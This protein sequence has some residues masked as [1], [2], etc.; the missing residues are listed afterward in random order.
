M[1]ARSYKVY[2]ESYPYF[3]TSGIRFGL[4]IFSDPGA[5]DIILENLV[6]L[7]QNKRIMI[8]AYVIMENHF[9]AIFRGENLTNDIGRFKSYSARRI[10]DLFR[11]KRRTRWLKRLKRVKLK[12]KKD[13]EYQLWEEGFHPKQIIS[14]KMMIQKIDYIH[15]NPVKRGFVDE[16]VHWRY[17]SAR[18]YAG[19]DGLI[20]VELFRGYGK[21]YRSKKL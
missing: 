1:C 18:N 14:D 12:F 8:I 11:E 7:Q 20:S 17:S 21:M 16:A 15:Q 10:I 4:P 19:L 9:H 2:D 5:V 3:V 13:R 6:F